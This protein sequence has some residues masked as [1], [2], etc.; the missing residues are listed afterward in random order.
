[1]NKILTVGITGGIG[2]GKTTVAKV[3]TLLG[4]PLYNADERA[5][6]LVHENL[7][8]KKS[9]IELMG[10]QAYFPDGRYNT[11][12]IKQQIF[13][14]NILLNQLNQLI[15]PAVSVDFARWVSKQSGT[16]VLKEAALL[17]ESGSYK[18][19]DW[20]IVVTAPM[21][22]RLQ[23]IQQRDCRSVEEINQIMT[24]QLGDD[25][26]I[27]KAN[28]TIANDNKILVIPQVL[29]IDEQLRQLASRQ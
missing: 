8:L 1:M 2:V 26:K 24:L 23:R 22:I 7:N 10:V 27:A 17:V 18:E 3:F 5:K 21:S 28:F 15:H 4:V 9:I 13:S 16:Y 14:N 19:L 6:L 25:A 12:H 20:L 29:A 11:T